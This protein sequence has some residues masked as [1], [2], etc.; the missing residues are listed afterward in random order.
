MNP[1]LQHQFNKKNIVIELENV[2][3][4]IADVA[5][6]ALLEEVS[7]TPKPGLVD[8]YS[9]GAHKDMNLKTFIDSAE[10]L[11]PYFKQMTMS[12]FLHFDNLKELFPK[13]REIGRFAE[14][15]M[16]DATG[17]V[18]THKGLIFSLGI[19]SAAAAIVYRDKGAFI[20]DEIFST[21]VEMVQK[22]LLA[23]LC[24][25]PLLTPKT[26]GEMIY[27]KYGSMGVRG[28]AAFGY[29]T[30]QKIALPELYKGMALSED[31]ERVKLQTLLKLMANVEDSNIISRSNPARLAQVQN[32][33]KE[34][35][36]A[37]GA[38]RKDTFDI[39]K[40][41]DEKFIEWNI[42]PGGCADLLAISLFMFRLTGGLG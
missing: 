10:A 11:H 12:G 4:Y 17:G 26:H 6:W 28:E 9:N 21:Q 33:A 29:Q 7:T 23:E 5:Q 16:Y 36:E 20:C 24:C 37:G 15:A 39:L 3:K 2:T 32:M 25:M 40:K 19:L 8:C 22:T 1:S 13:L 35:C 38:Y 31:F 14:E 41:W 27:R 30:V 18:N 42:S 34:F